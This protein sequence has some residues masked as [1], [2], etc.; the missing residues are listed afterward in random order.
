MT[1]Y[2]AEIALNRFG[3]GAAGNQLDEIAADPRGWLLMQL[4]P[5]TFNQ[6]SWSSTK[7][8]EKFSKFRQEKRS[9]RQQQG[10]M[11]EASQEQ[12]KQMTAAMLTTHR[13]EIIRE[14]KKMAVGIIKNG[15]NSEFSFQAR[16]LDFFSNHFSVTGKNVNMK[17]LAPTLEREAIAPNLAGYFHEMLLA[18]ESHPAMLVYLNNESSIGPDSVAGRKNSKRGINENL[19]REI[20]ELH[21]LGVQGGY[22]QQDVREL[23]MAISGWSVGFPHR[24]E[25]AGFRFR[26]NAHQPGKRV[27]MGKNY[28]AGGVDQ[29][30]RILRDLAAHPSTAHYVSFKLARHFIADEPP[31]ELVKAMAESWLDSGGYL[32]K[33]LT[34]LIEHPQSWQLQKQ[35]FKT[36]REFVISVCR[37]CGTK[38]TVKPNLLETLQLLGQMPFNAGSPAGYGDT[39]QH[40]AG[41][42]ALMTRIE[43][44]EQFSNIIKKEPLSVAQ[45]CLGEALQKRTAQTIMRAENAQQGLAILLM[46][47]E[48]QYR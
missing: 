23:A 36:P 37:G 6:Q 39:M 7:A 10:T 47:P 3:Y 21:T 9:I 15:I 35:K 8:I 20:L 45:R 40:W 1:N 43:W 38:S 11:K 32:K 46:S 28:Q 33:V 25:T 42:E 2:S 31:E 48:F 12:M 18:V 34:V 41:A 30:K 44:A 26:T 13:K 27:V 29:G 22:N 5:L 14:A 4:K 19:A 17:G 16:L 24:K